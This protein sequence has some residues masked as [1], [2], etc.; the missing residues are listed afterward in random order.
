MAMLI[1]LASDRI[2]TAHWTTPVGRFR[3][4][5]LVQWET[6]LTHATHAIREPRLPYQRSNETLLILGTCNVH[7]PQYSVRR[8]SANTFQRRG[9]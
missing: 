3:L 4:G 2:A 8:P 5:H 9:G 7:G 6:F 1:E